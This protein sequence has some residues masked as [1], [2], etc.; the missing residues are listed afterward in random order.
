VKKHS[1]SDQ[2]LRNEA[3]KREKAA[4]QSSQAVSQEGNHSQSGGPKCLTFT[5]VT[6]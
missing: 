6:T 4:A 3:R 1:M 5:E 2:K